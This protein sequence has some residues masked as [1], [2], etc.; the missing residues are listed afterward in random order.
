MP[1][2][3]RH[4]YVTEL[5]GTVC[6]SPERVVTYKLSRE[7]S[8][9]EQAS[10]RDSLVDYASSSPSKCNNDPEIEVSCQSMK[11]TAIT[12]LESCQSFE[13]RH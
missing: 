11:F 1:D 2:S 10:S 12:P 3:E 8:F 4:S 5:L 13:N 7:S 6:G 9:I